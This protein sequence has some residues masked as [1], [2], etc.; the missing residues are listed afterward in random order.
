MSP[1]TDIHQH[2]LWGMDDGAETPQVMREMLFE[3]HRQ[4]IRCVA[5]TP[6]AA[7]GIRPFDMGIYRERLAQAR[8]FCLREHLA[9]EVLPGAELAWT[10]HTVRM[11]R[12]KRVPT[13]GGSDHVLL[14]LWRDVTWQQARDAAKQ[15]TRAGYCPVLAHAERYTAFLLSP[16]EA[17][18]F[19][20]ETGALLQV[21][22]ETLLRPRGLLQRRFVRRMLGGRWIDAVASDAH[23]CEHRPIRLAQAQQWLIQH[24]DAAYAREL[25]DFGGLFT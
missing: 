16:G 5:A 2:L 7:P 22:A 19:R 24:T 9:L 25:T 10:E 11:L 6:H 14:E 21:N 17:A 20:R 8:E 12:Q 15:L 23:D 13:I 4:G 3:A 1:M 18:E